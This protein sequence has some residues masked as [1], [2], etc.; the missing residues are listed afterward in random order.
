MLHQLDQIS[1][2]R[3]QV[4]VTIRTGE[5]K[6]VSTLPTITS[7]TLGLFD[8]AQSLPEKLATDL[9]VTA[10]N[11]DTITA[12]S[13]FSSVSQM[14]FGAAEEITVFTKVFTGQLAI[15]P[16]TIQELERL[17]AA[18]NLG[19]TQRRAWPTPSSRRP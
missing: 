18:Q 10:T 9:G 6:N 3:K 4:D 17:I 16:S 8:A 13:V 19:L 15:N 14:G 11:R 7:A 1:E 2:I 12:G 5:L